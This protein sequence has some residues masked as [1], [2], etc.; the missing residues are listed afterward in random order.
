MSSCILFRFISLLL[1]HVHGTQLFPAH[2]AILHIIELAPA[3]KDEDEDE[4]T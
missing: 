1:H 2:D 3:M 4:T